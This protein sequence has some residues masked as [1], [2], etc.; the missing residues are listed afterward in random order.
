MLDSVRFSIIF[1][2]TAMLMS[3][4]SLYS[5]MLPMHMFCMTMTNLLFLTFRASLD[6]NIS[7]LLRILWHV[8][9]ELVARIADLES[10]WDRRWIWQGVVVDIVQMTI[11]EWR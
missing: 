1:M 8:E 11:A 10:V 7:S 5:V 9:G 3:M 2:P 6:N 4:V